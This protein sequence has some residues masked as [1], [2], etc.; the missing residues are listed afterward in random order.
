MFAVIWQDKHSD[1]D[2]YL[3]SKEED[4]V[5]WAKTK[6]REY[7]NSYG[8]EFEEETPDWCIYYG[9]YSCEGDG[10]TVHEVSVD[11]P[12]RIAEIQVF[13]DKFKGEGI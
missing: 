8:W 11:D 2:V 7:A 1:A 4:A 5:N 13:I 6:V 10:L 9:S 12:K 3:C